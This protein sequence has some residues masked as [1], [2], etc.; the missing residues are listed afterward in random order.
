MHLVKNMLMDRGVFDAQIRV[1][2]I[3]GVWGGKGQGKTFQTE[4]A[5]KKLGCAAQPALLTSLA[6]GPG[7]LLCAFAKKQSRCCGGS[8]GG[9][10]IFCDVV[11]DTRNVQL[12]KEGF[13]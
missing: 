5:L 4:L 11:S 6:C 10:C 12:A 8:F 2:L 9:T 3:L 1:P 7:D 13:W